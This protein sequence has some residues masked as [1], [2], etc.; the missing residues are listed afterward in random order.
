MGRLKD[1]IHKVGAFL[2]G[3]WSEWMYAKL[4]GYGTVIVELEFSSSKS[5]ALIDST[6]AKKG[7][8]IE[9]DDRWST[10]HALTIARTGIGLVGISTRD[11]AIKDIRTVLSTLPNSLV[12]LEPN[13]IHPDFSQMPLWI[14]DKRESLVKI[15]KGKSP[16][17]YGTKAAALRRFTQLHHGV[18][19]MPANSAAHLEETTHGMEKDAPTSATG[20][21]WQ[22]VLTCLMASTFVLGWWAYE[23]MKTSLSDTP[24]SPTSH[25]PSLCLLLGCWLLLC[26]GLQYWVL[27]IANRAGQF[28]DSDFSIRLL[29]D[30]DSAKSLAVR[31]ALYGFEWPSKETV[32]DSG[33]KAYMRWKAVFWELALAGSCCVSGAMAP[34]IWDSLPENPTG[35]GGAV[36]VFALLG[37]VWLGWH[38]TKAHGLLGQRPLP[39]LA[40]NI[41]SA[42]VALAILIRFPAWAYLEGSGAGYLVSA[43]DWTQLV[44]FSGSLVGLTAVVALAWVMIWFGKRQAGIIQFLMSVL[45]VAL[46]LLGFLS[47]AENEMTHGYNLRVQGTAEFARLN[48][49]VRACMQT[50]SNPEVSK[51]VWVFGSANNQVIVTKR[52]LTEEPLK[53][54]GQVSSLPADSVSLHLVQEARTAADGVA[55]PT[56]SMK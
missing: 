43:V 37:L 28:R 32:A 23:A 44:S 11:T 55:C 30:K 49:P 16:S 17:I 6:L 47:I 31:R 36:V 46:V 35:L 40:F 9:N 21:V 29:R 7:W 33:T 4:N 26:Q 45:S 20:R 34:A 50:L 39:R 12:L 51:A 38:L 52:S 3:S 54:A 5:R 22:R 53:E 15:P 48:Y 10:D 24:F 1:T 56:T 41:G 8:E 19:V 42:T 2:G 27:R 13:F 14:I 18:K 25:V